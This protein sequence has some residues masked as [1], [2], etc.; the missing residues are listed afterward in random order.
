M[1]EQYVQSESWPEYRTVADI[2]RDALYHRLHWA[3]EQKHR[4]NFPNVA[5]AVIRERYRK[6]LEQDA[7]YEQE[8]RE[9]RNQ[10]D[11]TLTQM[12]QRDEHESVMSY[13]EDLLADIDSFHGRE[14]EKLINQIQTFMERAKGRW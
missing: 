3:S 12:L 9:F 4:G 7:Q 8:M 1:M 10:I 14:Q 2:V 5:Q 11:V 6:R 13:C